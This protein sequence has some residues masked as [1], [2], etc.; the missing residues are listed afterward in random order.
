MSETQRSAVALRNIIVGTL[1]VVDLSSFKCA[2][3]AP[4]Y[5]PVRSLLASAGVPYCALHDLDETRPRVSLRMRLRTFASAMQ[6]RG[7]APWS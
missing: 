3:D 5:A 1:G 6:A 4:T 2:Q 7:L